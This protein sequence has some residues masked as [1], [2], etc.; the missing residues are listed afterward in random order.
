[1]TDICAMGALGLKEV[2]AVLHRFLFAQSVRYVAQRTSYWWWGLVTRNVQ[3]CKRGGVAS[4]STAVACKC[5]REIEN[6]FHL[7]G[8][9]WMFL[10]A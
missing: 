10:S 4:L 7:S 1:M 8:A 6:Q 5:K 9:F 3:P 2:W